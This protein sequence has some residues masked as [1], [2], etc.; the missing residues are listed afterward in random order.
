MTEDTDEPAEPTED[1]I[2]ER[3]VRVNRATRGALAA[4]LGLEAFAVLLVPRA[5]AQTPTGLG[6]LRTGLL[7][8][9]AA[10]LVGAAFVQR[11]RWGIALG[12]LVQAP[13]V[14]VGVWVH[15]FF[16]VGVLFVAVW[17]YLLNLRHD[18]VGTPGGPRMLIS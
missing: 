18:L 10:V 11:R 13:F 4:V 2:A 12:S 16:V 9:L 8:G 6:G 14:A 3:Q 17:L 1:Q 5:I 15:A 7:V